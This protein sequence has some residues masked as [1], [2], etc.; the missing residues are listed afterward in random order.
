MLTESLKIFIKKYLEEDV[1]NIGEPKSGYRNKSYKILL[2]NNQ[3]INFLLLKDE[4]NINTRI[5]LSN[6]ISDYLASTNFPSR[7]SLFN[8]R[9]FKLN[10]KKGQIRYGCFYNY[11]NGNTIPWDGYASKH[12]KN[13]GGKMG[14]MHGILDNSEELIV[15]SLPEEIV[16]QQGNLDRMAIYFSD[17]NVINAL[18]SKLNLAINFELLSFHNLFNLFHFTEKQV[19]HMDFVRGNILFD[20]SAN[21]TGVLDF[22]KVS[23]GPRIFDIAR[24]LS[25]LIIDCKYINDAKVRLYF[26]INGYKKRGN[27]LLPDIK[28]LNHLI[29]YFL[30]YDFYKFLKYNPYESLLLNEHFL[31]TREYLLKYK[32]LSSL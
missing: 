1:V 22:E 25:F 31:R 19:L 14:E 5:E 15:N 3:T 4:K 7:K 24:T 8:S 20:E 10:D 27:N 6:I 12:I 30:I 28:L 11:L 2:T 26:L 18:R 13:L 9:I 23:F 17:D 16:I 32:I 21:I 29:L